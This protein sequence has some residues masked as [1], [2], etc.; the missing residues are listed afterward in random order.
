MNRISVTV[1][2]F[3]PLGEQ[4]GEKTARFEF[5][6]GCVYGDLLD[7]IGRRFG[8]RFHPRLW[9]SDQ[10]EFKAGILVVGEGRDLET[11]DTLLVDDEN[12]RIIPVFAGG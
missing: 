10:N 5:S 12:I 7:E 2:F 6:Q 4:I 1:T 3:G 8:G 11:R 9:D